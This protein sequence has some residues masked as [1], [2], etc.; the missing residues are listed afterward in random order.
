MVRG[1]DVDARTDLRSRADLDVAGHR[2]G[3]PGGETR[4]KSPEPGCRAIVAA[5]RAAGPC[6][7]AE[8]AR[9]LAQL[10]A[11]GPRHRAGR[12]SQQSAGQAR[13]LAEGFGWDLGIGPVEVDA[14]PVVFVVSLLRMA[15]D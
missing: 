6:L 12:I 7:L 4:H 1:V 10:V 9:V 14:A 15:C 2:A 11:C 13:R 3:Y 5:E 8:T